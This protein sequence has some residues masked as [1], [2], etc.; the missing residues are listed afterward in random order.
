MV[1]D[2]FSKVPPKGVTLERE[3]NGLTLTYRRNVSYLNLAFILL[4][5]VVFGYTVIFRG[6]GEQFLARGFDL[7]TAAF[8]VLFLGGVIVV[9]CSIFFMLFG[10]RTLHLNNG[11]G[12]VFCGIWKLGWTWDFTYDST[13]CVSIQERRVDAKKGYRLLKEI[14]IQTQDKSFSFGDS[15]DVDEVRD[16]IIAVLDREIHLV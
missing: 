11:R 6:F 12:T 16:F 7:N 4:F 1:N 8:G 9:I 10:K 15:I 14:N 2:I 5:M 3:G 13:S